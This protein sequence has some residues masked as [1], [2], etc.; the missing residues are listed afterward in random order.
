N[1]PRDGETAFYMN[2]GDYVRAIE[3]AREKGETITAVYH[4]HVGAGAYFSELD[5]AFANQQLFPFPDALHFVISVV[6]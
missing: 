3:H 2:E 6:D 4:S 1:F 5:Q